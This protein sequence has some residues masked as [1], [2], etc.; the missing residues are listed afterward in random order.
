MENGWSQDRGM[1]ASLPDC[2][3]KST[4]FEQWQIR[5]ALDQPVG[6]SPELP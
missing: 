4:A 3:C 2:D 6:G 1:I 5:Y